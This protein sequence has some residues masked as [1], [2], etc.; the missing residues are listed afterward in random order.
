[1]SHY[2]HLS[3]LEREMIGELHRNGIGVRGIAKELGRSA[4]TISREL[5]RNTPAKRK[6]YG[7]VAQKLYSRRRNACG[8]KELLSNSE[9]LLLVKRLFL[10]FQF[11]PEQISNRLK[12]E[13]SL[14]QISYT[15]IYRGIRNHTFDQFLPKEKKASRKLRHRGKTRKNRDFQEKRG[16]IQVD[17]TIAERP[18]RANS[19]RYFGH[20]EADTVN[21]KKGTACILTL[22]DRRSRYLIAAKVEKNNPHLIRD[23]LIELMSNVPH[24]PCCSITPDRGQEFRYHR[25]VTAA[26]GGVKLYFCDPQ[27]PWQRGTN[28]NSNGLLREYIP[29]G[30]DMNLL[31]EEY[32]NHAVEKLNLRPRKC[33]GWKSPYEVFFAKVLHLT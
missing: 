8:R 31:T 13:K 32:L 29:K 3:M 14:F 33:L 26:L 5:R 23:K 10:D 24:H 25:E 19:R 7:C 15:T 1:M 20:F 28:E 2:I 21:G 30:Y 22:N 17:Y 16:K 27:S 6:Y 11:S 18:E 12:L 4:S 9:L